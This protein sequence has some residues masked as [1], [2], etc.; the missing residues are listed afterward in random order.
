M[1]KVA[2]ASALEGT[3]EAIKTATYTEFAK[4]RAYL[5]GPKKKS[6]AQDHSALRIRWENESGRRHLC[7]QGY[8]NKYNGPFM[9]LSFPAFYTFFYVHNRKSNKP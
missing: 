4:A 3:T 2:M 7:V 6:R 8:G 5:P 1:A 9:S